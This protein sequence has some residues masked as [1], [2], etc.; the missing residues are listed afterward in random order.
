M[1][2]RIFVIAV[3][4]VLCYSKSYFTS[5]ND[6]T[7]DDL[8]S[9]FLTAI[10][11]FATEI[12]GGEI[13]ALNFRNFNFIYGYDK[14]F[15]T[16][17][18]IVSDIDDPEEE[19]R[20]KLD[21]MKTE[22]I[23]RYDKIL[24]NFNGCISDF[25]TF[26]DYIEEN[27]YIPPKIILLGELG[28]G[29]TTIMNLFPGETILELDDDLNEIIQKVV[30]VSNLP[31]LKQFLLRE[32]DFEDLINNSKIYRQFLDSVDV[33]YIVTNSAGS[34]LGR[35]KKLYLRLK[36]LV[37]K[38]DVFIIANFQ[39]QKS[40]SFVPEKIEESFGLKTFGFS[41]IKPDAKDKIFSIVIDILKNSVIEKIR[42]KERLQINNTN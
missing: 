6:N 22:F 38:A 8:V 11:N 33:I 3:G 35:T 39:D 34:N 4:G 18:V 41:A 23:K 2:S 42:K 37:K 7:F 17:F 12:K 15:G 36:P 30:S 21:A 25:R 19:I 5:E 20:K 14:K 31:N 24:E 10:S 1:I 13:K 26:D 40:I 32:I 9:G 27:I 28:V 16:I 29:K